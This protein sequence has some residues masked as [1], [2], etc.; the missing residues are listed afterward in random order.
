MQNDTDAI[1]ELYAP[2]ILVELVRTL[3]TIAQVKKWSIS[4][5]DFNGAFLN[6]QL[7]NIKRYG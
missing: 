7:K 4:H 1:M 5:L 6:T 2:V 3:L